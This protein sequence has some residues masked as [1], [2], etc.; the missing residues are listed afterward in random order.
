[1]RRHFLVPLLL[2]V[3]TGCTINTDYFSEYRGTNL[4]G[5]YDFGAADA[6]G[7]PRWNLAVSSDFM[8][9]EAVTNVAPPAG[10]TGPVYRLEIKNLIP[11][12]DF[13]DA[14]I[15]PEGST[16]VPTNWSLYNA[17]NGPGSVVYRKDAT[18]QLPTRSLQWEGTEVGNQLRLDLKQAAG[19]GWN[20]AK[21]ILRFHYINLSSTANLYMFLLDQATSKPVS[22]PTEA[23]SNWDQNNGADLADKVK[24]YPFVKYFSKSTLN[25]GFSFVLG[26]AGSTGVYAARIDNIRLLPDSQELTVQAQFP[27]LSS[28]SLPL[29]P[30]SK[31]GMYTF[32]FQI[33]DDPTVGTGNR[34]HPS[35]VTVRLKAKVKSGSG[36]DREVVNRPAAGWADWTIVSVQTGFDFVNSDQALEGS[37]ALVIDIAPTLTGEGLVDTGSVLI[38][39]PKLT[40]NP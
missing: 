29:L 19:L 3:L 20:Q 9:W 5:T 27:S 28:G 1:M 37:S 22:N 6:Q 33:K 14:A 38:T 18:S 17:G 21:Y 36:T 40:F 25:Q 11:N 26:P 30:G 23:E 2:A 32:S 39:R 10:W 15:T 8:T 34:Y 31:P 35:A 13:E 24:A 12:G 7:K 16:S 4:L